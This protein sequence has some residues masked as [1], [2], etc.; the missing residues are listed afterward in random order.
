MHWLIKSPKKK[1][2]QDS[3]YAF[4]RGGQG[5]RERIDQFGL[6]VGEPHQETGLVN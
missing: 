6:N 1:R 3:F 4:R 2:C 5:G